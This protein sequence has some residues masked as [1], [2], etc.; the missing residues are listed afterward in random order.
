MAIR[1][2]DIQ[3]QR[4]V[5]ERS[6]A[7]TPEP[8]AEPTPINESVSNIDVGGVENI[9]SWR[10]VGVSP[11]TANPVSGIVPEPEPVER[12]PARPRGATFELRFQDLNSVLDSSLVTGY[13][14]TASSNGDW[15]GYY[16]GLSSN[17]QVGKATL[18]AVGQPSLF[19]IAGGVS[20][21][22]TAYRPQIT[23]YGVDTSAAG[24]R[25]GATITSV[26]QATN[27]VNIIVSS[28]S[29]NILVSDPTQRWNIS[30][31][32]LGGGGGG[33]AG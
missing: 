13:G 24:T 11:I 7:A 10:V 19:V 31:I 29:R 32:P 25:W 26:N 14:L 23:I 1:W 8:V 9:P 33:G 3:A 17:T 27:T 6:L 4:A 5:R 2:N 20:L 18:F 28:L 16:P 21:S 22:N 12:F 15:V 30:N